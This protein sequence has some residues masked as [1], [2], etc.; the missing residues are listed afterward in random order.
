[1]SDIRLVA[2]GPPAVGKTSIIKR[3]LFN[4]Y[5]DKYKPTIEDLF[6][7]EFQLNGVKIKVDILDTAGQVEFPAMRR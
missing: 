7:K 1:M 2:L 4:T 5:T 3:F 6:S